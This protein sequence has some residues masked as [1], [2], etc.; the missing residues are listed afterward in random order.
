MS[1]PINPNNKVKL[2]LSRFKWCTLMKE[3]SIINIKN[4]RIFYIKITKYAYRFNVIE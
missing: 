3:C 4:I 1:N 2:L